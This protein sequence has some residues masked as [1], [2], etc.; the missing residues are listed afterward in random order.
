MIQTMFEFT[1]LSEFTMVNT[2]FCSKPSVL[3]KEF[4]VMFETIR[5]GN[6]GNG[7]FIAFVKVKAL[8]N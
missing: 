5:S 1:V 8:S 7:V 3:K 6:Y 2:I 4:I